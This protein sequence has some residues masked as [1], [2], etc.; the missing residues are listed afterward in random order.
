MSLICRVPSNDERLNLSPEPL[1]FIR[2]LIARCWSVEP[3]DLPDCSEM[4]DQH[5]EN[6]FQI[7]ADI[8]NGCVRAYERQMSHESR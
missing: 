2:E 8:D 7:L 6:D 1:D 4:R 5:R 3:Q